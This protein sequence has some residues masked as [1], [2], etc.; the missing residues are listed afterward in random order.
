VPVAHDPAWVPVKQAQ[1]QENA[2]AAEQAD[3]SEQRVVLLALRGV[4]EAVR[5][6][7]YDQARVAGWRI[8]NLGYF[9]MRIPRPS[10]ADG[11][12]F[13]LSEQAAT[14]R[15][16]LR[17]GV[18]VVQVGDY[19]HSK[20]CRC[21]VSDQRA[22]GRVAAEH[23]AERGFRSMA[24]L[25]SEGFRTSR[26]RLI[27]ESFLDRARSLG[28]EARFIAVQRPG[29]TVP[30][31]RFDTLT[32]RLKKEI[33]RLELPLGIF[34]YHDTM[35]V[36]ICALCEALNLAVPEQVA[37]LGHGNELDQC[38]F[39][40][41]P[42]SSLDP[43]YYEQGRAAVDLLDRLMNGEPAPDGPL[44]IPPAGIVTR[45]S[46]DV[47]AVPD[48]D[49]ARAL[50]Y[51]WQRLDEPL[52]AGDIAEAVGISRRALYRSF[53]NH[54]G[55]SVNEEL[56]RKRIERCCELLTGTRQTVVSIARQVGFRT[57]PY[58]FSV[59]RKQMGMTPRQYRLAHTGR[60]REVRGPEPLTRPGAL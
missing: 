46:T 44:M 38:E 56:N 42:L 59:F 49:T 58:L 16:L 25:H 27:G 30:W 19:I 39:A 43:N 29:Q 21:V 6:G 1:G 48:V 57:E 10:R 41:T 20:R 52:S 14:A 3:R 31:S 23:F 51:M 50:R 22:M 12:L 2:M 9:D 37:V 15:R 7:I 34:T 13:M 32:K 47:L 28:A 11:A 36:R 54:V 8:R 60:Q 18:P 24:Y 40:P 26:F 35:A 53:K 33:S 45:Q 55:R 5:R 4:I 17:L